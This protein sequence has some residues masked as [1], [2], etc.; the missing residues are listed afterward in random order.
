MTPPME[1]PV[2][3]ASLRDFPYRRHDG[4]DSD[5]L[6]QAARGWMDAVH[7]F[8]TDALD[9]GVPAG[10]V[11]PAV[12]QMLEGW[13]LAR[14]AA[15]LATTWMALDAAVTVLERRLADV[16]AQR[17]DLAAQNTVLLA[18]RRAR[19]KSRQRRRGRRGK[20]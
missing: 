14:D 7:M 19:R 8:A 11:L 6:G 9:A 2:E 12:V 5:D 16:R 1:K 17:D 15:A 3:R 18:E 20:N 10:E 4:G 13:M